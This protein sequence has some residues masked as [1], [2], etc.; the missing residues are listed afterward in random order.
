MVLFSGK[1]Y[2]LEYD[3]LNRLIHED[4]GIQDKS[5]LYTYDAGGNLTSVK[6][7]AY[8]TDTPSQL[9]ATSTGT[10][11]MQSMN[12]SCEAD[13]VHEGA[14]CPVDIRLAPTE[15]ERR[16]SDSGRRALGVFRAS[17]LLFR[18]SVEGPDGELDRRSHR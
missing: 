7:Y 4:S 17:A 3:F 5:I 10:Y 12:A 16:R 9:L 1:T 11:Q 13:C 8:T 6:E 14:G 2:D 18:G 15:A